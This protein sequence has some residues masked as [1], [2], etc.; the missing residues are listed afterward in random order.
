MI[1]A[2]EGA[3]RGNLGGFLLR[4]EKNTH[5]SLLSSALKGEGRKVPFSP[6][7]LLRCAVARMGRGGGGAFLS[8]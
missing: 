8:H 7:L 2:D 6:F 4:Q 5:S 3:G 1:P